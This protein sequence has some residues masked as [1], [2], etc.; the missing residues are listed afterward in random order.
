MSEEAL[1]GGGGGGW[2]GGRTC[3][4]EHE[5]GPPPCHECIRTTLR[6]TVLALVKTQMLAHLCVA[7]I[8]LLSQHWT[9]YRQ[10]MRP[11]PV[12]TFTQLLI[13]PN[14]ILYQNKGWQKLSNYSIKFSLKKKKKYRCL[15]F[16]GWES[17]PPD[18]AESNIHNFLRASKA[19]AK[20][21]LSL[22]FYGWAVTTGCQ[23][24]TL[25]LTF[26][27]IPKPDQHS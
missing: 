2:E 24:I 8:Q 4:A 20:K 14:K 12:T 11:F 19:W 6:V 26:P 7:K 18:Q 3:C 10:D 22:L 13:F 15:S 17:E 25:D 21:W 9:L 5:S 1:G 27:P 16:P 23:C